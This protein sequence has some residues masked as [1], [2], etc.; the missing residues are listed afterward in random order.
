MIRVVCPACAYG[1]VRAGR[2]AGTRCTVMLA[3]VGL[4]MGQ[5]SSLI[6]SIAQLFGVLEGYAKLSLKKYRPIAARNEDANVFRGL[7]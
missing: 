1:S 7:L 4:S 5:V 2:A 3:E 6:S